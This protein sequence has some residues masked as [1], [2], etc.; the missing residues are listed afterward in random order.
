MK[1]AIDSNIEVALDREYKDK[2]RARLDA[3]L[4]SDNWYYF[5]RGWDEPDIA[6]VTAG[7]RPTLTTTLNPTTPNQDNS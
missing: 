5:S 2:E 6:T 1:F 3:Y 4:N 7:T